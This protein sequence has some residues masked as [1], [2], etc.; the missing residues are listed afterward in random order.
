MDFHD[1]LGTDGLGAV[2]GGV[3]GGI[4]GAAV[5]AV[6]GASVGAPTVATGPGFAITEP[7]ANWYHCG[8]MVG[9]AA[10]LQSGIQQGANINLGGMIQSSIQNYVYYSKQRVADTGVEAQVKKLMGENAGMTEQEALNKLR[11]QATGKARTKIEATEKAKGY[12]NKAKRG[13]CP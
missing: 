12:R 4:A 7:V 13:K 2:V 3:V 8:A 1:P 5:G 6:A 10:G 9:G 11:G